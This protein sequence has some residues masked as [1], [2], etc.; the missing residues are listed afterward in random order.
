[1][2]PKAQRR[3]VLIGGIVLLLLGVYVLAFLLPDYLAV[4]GGPQELT[5][6]EAASVASDERTY[7]T[8]ID[9]NWDCP[10]LREVRGVSGSALRYNRLRETTRST[11]IFYTNSSRDAVAF[12]VLSGAVTCNDLVSQQPTGYLYSMDPAMQ[13]SLTNDAR[14]ARYPG[15][16]AFLEMCG[17]CGAENSLIGIV[18]G[19]V[20][21]VLGVVLLIWYR[22]L[23]K[24][25]A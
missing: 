16:G 4:A 10:T 15:S 19:T 12:V 23:R 5:L 9:G 21:T 13:Q 18:F 24:Q 7:A 1:M 3:S 8:L 11:E 14:L 20:F 25:A 17:Y 22:R 2:S 6:S